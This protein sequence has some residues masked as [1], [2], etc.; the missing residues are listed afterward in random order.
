M[1]ATAPAVDEKVDELLAVLDTDIRYIRENLSTLNEL[2]GSVLRRDDAALG[3]LLDRIRAESDGYRANEMK[4]QSIRKQLADILDCQFEQMTLS[5]LETV[6]PAEKGMQITHRRTQ[7]APL[8]TELK[9]EHSSTMLLLAE[10]AR[11]NSLLLTSIFDL[12]KTEMLVY[13][14]KGAASQQADNLFVNYH[15]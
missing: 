4:R 2:R 9:R 10:C 3:R 13:N 11:F 12:A 15:F 14:P 8:V 5:K 6:L 7:L 1:K